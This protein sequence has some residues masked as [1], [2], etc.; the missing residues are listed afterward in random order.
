MITKRTA[1]AKILVD[2]CVWS[3]VLRSNHPDPALTEALKDMISNHSVALIGPILQEILSGVSSKKVF[4][5]LK[6]RLAP[7]DILPIS[8]EYL[9]DSGRIFQYLQ[10]TGH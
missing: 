4:S 3:K 7:F 8:P 2:T 6:N 9:F 1:L 10:K 5:I